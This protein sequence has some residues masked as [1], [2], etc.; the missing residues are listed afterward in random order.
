[1]T[2]AVLFETPRDADDWHRWSF[3]HRDS[4]DRIRQ[5]IAAQGGPELPDYPV[6]AINQDSFG[7]FLQ[8]NS[9]LHSDMNSELHLQSADLQSVEFDDEAQRLSWIQLHAQEH[10]DAELRLNI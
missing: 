5:A 4:H 6:D 9:Q 10:R 1:M 2:L 8:Y 3:H 7:G